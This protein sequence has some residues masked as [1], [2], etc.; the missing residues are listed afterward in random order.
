M[1]EIRTLLLSIALSCLSL[2]GQHKR[3]SRAGATA[4]TSV[5]SDLDDASII[6]AMSMK[7]LELGSPLQSSREPRS[8]GLLL[9]PTALINKLDPF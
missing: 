7:S 3:M 9:H 5:L 8:E 1:S 4:R 2:T 6:W